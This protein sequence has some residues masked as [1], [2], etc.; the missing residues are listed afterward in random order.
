M[1][2]PRKPSGTPVPV[3]LAL[4][5]GG[6]HS[7]FSWGVID[8]LLADGRVTIEAVTATSGGA[9]AAVVLA[10]ALLRDGPEDAR[11]ALATFWRR[12]SIA[13]GMLPLRTS[14]VDKLLSNVGID[15]SPSSIA[16]D[17]LTRI[18]SPYQFN[19]FDLNPLRAI[20][21]EMVDF[22]A[23]RAQKEIQLF[24]STTE[25]KTG[26]SRVFTNKEL[27]LD[28]IMASSCLPF[29]FKTVL[30]DNEPYWDG[31]FS[32]NPALAPLIEARR[33]RNILLI[34][35]EP[36]ASDDV[37]T[38]AADILDRTLEISFNSVLLHELRAV[39][40]HNRREPEAALH[41]HTIE[42]S[43][44]IASLGRASKLNADWDFLTHLRDI[45]AQAAG[46]WLEAHFSDLQKKDMPPFPKAV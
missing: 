15:L 26:K 40:A 27:S 31:S 2:P 7:A 35:N 9:M 29:L 33:A 38:T 44:L 28:V 8:R 14:I 17:Y 23:L 39:E 32:G 20:V 18:F 30:I 13:T 25:V 34:Q 24:I 22:E 1:A 37:P 46:D 3:T 6:S 11:H 43:E 45:G 10:D 16:L 5:G 42:A 4:Q 36:V 41:I 19:L 12:V 21:E